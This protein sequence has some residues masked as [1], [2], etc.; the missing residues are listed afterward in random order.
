LADEVFVRRVA[1]LDDDPGHGFAQVDETG[2]NLGKRLDG[3]KKQQD[4]Y[5]AAHD[6]ERYHET[7]SRGHSPWP[8]RMG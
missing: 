3:E 4:K 1:K 2:L 7:P 8:R 6:A 5:E